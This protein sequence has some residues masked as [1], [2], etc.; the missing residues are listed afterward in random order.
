VRIRLRFEAVKRAI[1]NIDSVSA[2]DGS[3]L[4]RLSAMARF[5]QTGQEMQAK[6]KEC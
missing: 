4:L 3:R 1:P 6:V 2:E 5:E